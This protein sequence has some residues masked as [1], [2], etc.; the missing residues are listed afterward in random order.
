MVAYA[1]AVF[2]AMQ[3]DAATVHAYHGADSTSAFTGHGA[4]GIYVVC[5]TS[6]PGR[7]DLQ[8]LRGGEEPLFMAVADM[9]AHAD[10]GG[11]TGVVML[12]DLEAAG[13]IGPFSTSTV[14]RAFIRSAAR[15]SGFTTCAPTTSGTATVRR[16]IA[17]RATRGSSRTCSAT[18][19]RG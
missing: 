6:N 13:A 3:F 18:R 19:T 1:S 11:N 10:N 14:R 5:D 12:A 9:A 8:H 7:A 17:S 16:C 4:R 15:G 2:E